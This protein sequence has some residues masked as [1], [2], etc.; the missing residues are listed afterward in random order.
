MFRKRKSLSLRLQCPVSMPED[1]PINLPQI[2]V[3][4]FLPFRLMGP[5]C[6]MYRSSL[7]MC[8]LLPFIDDMDASHSK[9]AGNE[10][11]H[12]EGFVRFL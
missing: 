8:S 4:D 11:F 3:Q 5:V 12:V 9:E 2:F 6:S 1:F 10:V 7:R